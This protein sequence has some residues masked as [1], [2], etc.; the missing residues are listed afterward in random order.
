MAPLKIISLAAASALLMANATQGNTDSD[1]G[2]EEGQSSTYTVDLG[3]PNVCLDEIN[4]AREG[5]GLAHFL[6]AEKGLETWP[7][8]D[9]KSVSQ[10]AKPWDPV[11]D[12]LIKKEEEITVQQGA[13][14]NEFPS[15]TYAF[16]A[17]DTAEADCAAAVSHWKDAASNF[18][19]LPP[20]KTEGE[21][22]Y[23][24]QHNVSFIAMYNP[25]EKATADCR[26][27][28]CTQATTP[29]VFSSRSGAGEKKGYAL[30][31]M[32][33]PDALEDEEAP[34]TEEQ[35][36][37]IK[38][39]ITGSASAVAPKAEGEEL[40]EK[41]H[42]VSFIA[43]YN[44]SEK[45]TA[46][47]R[48]VTCTQTAASGK[49]V[50]SSRTSAGEKKGYALLCMTTPEA[51]KD[52]EAPF[53]GEAEGLDTSV[54]VSSKKGHHTTPGPTAGIAEGSHTGMCITA[55]LRACFYTSLRAY[56]HAFVRVA[57]ENS[58]SSNLPQ[59]A[60]FWLAKYRGEAEGL[61]TSVAVSSKKGHH[62]TPGPTA[63]IAEG[64]GFKTP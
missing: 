35:W 16:M 60:L 51:L 31:C 32:T 6:V 58:K 38:A 21:E 41:Q 20:P 10:Q 11:C 4:A 29:V 39:S 62:T 23:E 28:T 33:T 57:E 55:C 37:K 43:M 64:H 46:D 30:L 26:V 15:G 17:L 19:S 40:Y 59:H 61:D 34:F 47:C 56:L 24:K 7:K 14:G 52:A 53:T 18:T 22:L 48:I 27:V 25:S 45:A 9:A 50:F 44:P 3:E 13:E 5:A 42:N 36:K 8:T 12:A 1:D 63:G 54:A 49:I 2:L